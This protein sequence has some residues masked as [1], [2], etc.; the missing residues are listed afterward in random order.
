MKWRRMHNW[1]PRKFY[2]RWHPINLCPTEMLD[3]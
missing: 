3:S 1:K 2:A